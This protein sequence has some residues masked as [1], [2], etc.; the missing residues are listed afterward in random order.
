MLAEPQET[1]ADWSFT[2]FGIRVRVSAWFWAAAGLLGWNVCQSIA[3]GDQ[4]ML[5]WFG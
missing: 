3:Q 4:R 1:G 2:L 5:L